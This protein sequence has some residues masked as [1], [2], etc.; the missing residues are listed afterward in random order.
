MTNMRNLT[1]CLLVT[2][3]AATVTLNGCDS[4][5]DPIGGSPAV[6]TAGFTVVDADGNHIPFDGTG[7]GSTWTVPTIGGICDD[8]GAPG[9][10]GFFFVKFNKLLDGYAIQ[11][12]PTD[13]TP[14]AAL[15]LTFN[16]PA[17]AGSTWYA[18]YNPQSPNPNEGASVV[19]YQAP[20]ATLAIPPSAGWVDAAPIPASGIALTD[21][22]VAGTA[23]DKDGAAASFDV[24]GTILPDPGAAGLD[25]TGVVV[26][27][28]T[29]QLTWTASACNPAAEYKIERAPNNDH[30]T[31]ADPDD[32]APGTYAQ[33]G[34]TNVTTLTFTDTGRTAGTK[35]WYRVTSRTVIGAVEYPGPS[36]EI[37]ATTSP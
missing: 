33:L 5:E 17:P 26:T 35:Y 20:S 21:I 29:V 34:T 12:D 3:T 25:A 30:G 13:C 16:P 23:H 2:L 1:K 6:I 24:T 22:N 9:A 32:D 11:T 15:G 31:P 4:F 36:A 8:T 10:P 27:Q 14:V 37:D 28:T 18:C 7:S 19:I